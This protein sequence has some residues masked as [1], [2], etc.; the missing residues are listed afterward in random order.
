MASTVAD[1]LF[2]RPFDPSRCTQ[3]L[4]DTADTLAKHV[5]FLATASLV[6]VRLKTFG[7]QREIVAE[8]KRTVRQLAHG[9]DRKR[10]AALPLSSTLALVQPDVE[11]TVIIQ[12]FRPG[13]R[14]L[15]RATHFVQHVGLLLSGYISIGKLSRQLAGLREDIIGDGSAV[16]TKEAPV[17]AVVRPL[18][19]NESCTHDQSTVPGDMNP[20][21]ERIDRANPY[22]ASALPPELNRTAM[23][24]DLDG[25]IYMSKETE[26]LCGI[27]ETTMVPSSLEQLVQSFAAVGAQPCPTLAGFPLARA[28]HGET[29]RDYKMTIAGKHL[30]LVA[31]PNVDSSGDT[32][33]ATM[34]VHNVTEIILLEE[35][36]QKFRYMQENNADFLQLAEALP[37]LIYVSDAEGRC[38]FANGAWSTNTGVSLEEVMEK[39]GWSHIAHPADM[40]W[41]WNAW[42]ESLKT[43]TRFEA[44]VR[45]KSKEG[46]WRWHL[47]R[48]IPVINHHTGQVEKW[49]GTL[50]DIH[51]QKES[52]RIAKEVHEQLQRYIS[53]SMVIVWAVDAQGYFTFSDG[54]GLQALGL[55][56][57]EIVGQ[58]VW[59][60]YKDYPKVLELI[61]RVIYHGEKICEETTVMDLFFYN[62]WAPLRDDKGT[63][64]GCVGVST[65][66][67]STKLAQQA[68]AASERRAKRL[69]QSSP[70][71]VMT[72]STSGE[73]LDVNEA[74]LEM[75]GLQPRDV[76][77]AGL[78]TK[79]E[80]PNVLRLSVDDKI[81]AEA[82]AMKA[83]TKRT[84]EH[85]LKRPDGV[86][87]P[88]LIGLSPLDECNDQFVAFAVDLTEQIR[89][90]RQAEEAEQRLRDV[91][92][93][94]PGVFIWCISSSGII[95]VCDGKGLQVLRT[96]AP[97]VLHKHYHT[98]FGSVP[99][100][101]DCVR[102]AFAGE[103]LTHIIEVGR[104]SFETHFSHISSP[105]EETRVIGICTDITERLTAEKTLEKSLTERNALVARENAAQEASKLKSQFLA[106]MSH[107]LRTPISG[108]I[109]MTDLLLESDLNITQQEYASNIRLSA[110]CLLTVINDILDFSKV[111]AGKLEMDPV[112]FNVAN[113]VTDVIKIL[114]L[115]AMKKDIQ[116]DTIIQLQA[117]G[118][119]VGDASRIRQ[120]LI[121]LMSNAIKFTPVKGRIS[122][123]LSEVD[124]SS[125]HVQQYRFDVEDTGIGMSP[126][127]LER[128]FQ[129]FS[130]AESSTARRFGGTGL[131]L[132]IS[133]GLVQL[134]GG[135]ISVSST[136]GE[137]STFS[138]VLPLPTATVQSEHLL[139]VSQVPF[140]PQRSFTDKQVLVAEDNPINQVIASKL[141]QKL[142]IK[143]TM[144][145][146]GH[147]VLRALRG[148]EKFDLILMDCQMPGMD[149]FEATRCIRA[150]ENF[151]ISRIPIVAMSANVLESD[152]ARCLECGMSD[153]LGKPV[154]AR[155]LDRML[156]KWLYTN[157]LPDRTECQS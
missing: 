8:A 78:P 19:S 128:L 15:A 88:T 22:F 81:L 3:V 143:F 67:T 114:S 73:C 47:S 72:F 36:R 91:I 44:E 116:L 29:V 131:G 39:G 33:G 156:G 126:D 16:E 51:A 62:S 130:Q 109:G 2:S 82:L 108:V 38:L 71:G 105:G 102:R 63:I 95:T 30:W 84:F 134:M 152:K 139:P 129:P 93:N 64:A 138:F 70:I 121:N 89:L 127:V 133:K 69:I 23:T 100:L 12:A 61:E 10:Q 46:Q 97:E 119:V 18:I 122:V 136:E 98:L 27:S 112:S 146:D 43:R 148:S 157:R 151:E 153:H 110:E 24:C 53:N 144:V 13:R 103:S 48:S 83:Q 94:L 117:F 58:S 96:S 26:E 4:Q 132:S 28:L 50:T 21:P 111:E 45:L 55:R 87:I 32:I 154:K 101:D 75:L 14:N 155:D 31:A 106:T 52:L 59:E 118:N 34:I 20:S 80:Q 120:V 147:A 107:E 149:G 76:S 66:I 57:G 92:S 9:R 90:R 1:F 54:Q 145:E 42:N 25:I 125:E 77:D 85:Q 79:E 65:D 11:G 60:V 5:R 37:Q 86:I 6:T 49:F 135:T 142:N 140:N 56:P 113:L 137:G 7:C 68:L 115:S 35:G 40:K 141:L 123:R 17:D 41:S 74:Y 104:H 99:T 124:S 150:S